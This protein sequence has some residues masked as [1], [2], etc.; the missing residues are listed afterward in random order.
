M[1]VL[2]P[3]AIA[4]SSARAFP[5]LTGAGRERGGGAL[6]FP[7]PPQS[8]THLSITVVGPGS[9]GVSRDGQ[10]KVRTADE[11]EAGPVV[12]RQCPTPRRWCGTSQRG[13]ERRE[14]GGA[15]GAVP[16][17]RTAEVVRGIP[18]GAGRR[19]GQSAAQINNQDFLKSLPSEP[20]VEKK[21][22]ITSNATKGDPI[23]SEQASSR[24]SQSTRPP[25][26][27]RTK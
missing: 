4:P 14:G 7:S 12:P 27:T 11:A 2:P 5:R 3:P 17:S 23:N 26:P 13:R 24:A 15:S 18:K 22:K 10:G 20:K 1:C 9:G 16:V 25:F 8:P 19:R 21:I 6:L